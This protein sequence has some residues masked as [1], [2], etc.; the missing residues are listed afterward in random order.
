MLIGASMQTILALNIESR[1]QEDGDSTGSVS[2]AKFSGKTLHFPMG[3]GLVVAAI[4]SR[5][6]FD[7]SV[8]DNYI[9]GVSFSDILETVRTTRPDII[10]LTSFLGNYQYGFIKSA[11][12][13]FKKLSPGSV[14]II[15]GPMASCIPDLLLEKSLVDIVVIG[16][17]EATIID[18]LD[19]LKKGQPLDACTGIAYR[20]SGGRIVTTQSRPRIKQLS[21]FPHPAYELFN[22]KQYA[23]YVKHTGRCWEMS[24]SRGCYAKCTYCRLTFGSKISF[25]PY[26]HILNE[27]RFIIE[28]Y[29]IS[30][31]NFV[32]DNFLNSSRQVHEFVEALSGFEYPIQFR[33]QGRADKLTPTLAKM[34]VD[35]GCFDISMG[36][37][38]GSQRLLDS[39]KKCLDIR[40]AAENI[41]GILEFGVSVHATFIVGMPDEDSES[42][43]STIEFIRYTG[44]PYVAAGILTPFPDTEIYTLAKAKGLVLDDDT[45]CMSM[46][47]VYDYPYVNLTKYSNDQLLEWRDKIDSLSGK[48]AMVLDSGYSYA[49]T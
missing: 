44:L 42:I 33:F 19:R 3:L 18:L 49:R 30:R 32:D 7:I 34:L 17:G 37:E 5:T 14:I 24:T 11:I 21:E 6:T 47:R 38:S 4:K 1:P 28:N 40:A 23:D 13:S 10:L 25:R 41:K 48:S 36:I 29:Q 22:T 9:P 16:E 2:S 31:F 46:G 35:V 15:G 45:Y 43:A 20:D 12:D 26:D 8:M 39:M 27:M